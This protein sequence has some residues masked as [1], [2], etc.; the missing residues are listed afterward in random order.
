MINYHDV[1]SCK[2]EEYLV[3]KNNPKNLK[4]VH[5]KTGKTWNIPYYMATFVR[6]GTAA[7]I[8]KHETV[9]QTALNLGQPVMFT[10]YP[11]E[12]GVVF[13]VIGMTGGGIKIA[14]MFGSKDQFYRNVQPSA[15]KALTV[16][17]VQKA[18]IQL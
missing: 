8:A 11:K 9:A 3:T 12:E 13:T 1:I 14:K 10:S 5:L 16:L 7:D 6:K 18:L 15:L 17:E 4:T 2:G